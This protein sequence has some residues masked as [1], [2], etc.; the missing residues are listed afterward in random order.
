MKQGV[1][2]PLNQLGFNF[3]IF[4]IP[5]PCRCTRSSADGGG[6]STTTSSSSPVRLC[7]DRLALHVDE[8][9][10]GEYEEADGGDDDMDEADVH[11]ISVNQPDRRDRRGGGVAAAASRSSELTLAFEGEVFVFPTVTPEKVRG[12]VF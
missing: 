8:D 7:E 9:E 10:D 2:F 5:F 6:V 4:E 12:S 3:W 1:E 11:T